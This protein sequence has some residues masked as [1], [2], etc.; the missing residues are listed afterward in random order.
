MTCD[1]RQ[2]ATQPCDCCEGVR[3][4][5]PASHQN[6][7]GLPALRYRVG[8]HGQ[9][10][11]SMQAR[12][13]S[14]QVSGVGSD[15]QTP[16]LFR[17]LQG[18]T[19]RDPGD[20]SIALLD[21]WATV[22]DVLGFYQE[23]IA[24]E[25]YL[26][27]ATERRS[28]LELARLVGYA[29]RPG[30][31]ASVHLAYTLDARQ[32]VPA[33]LPVGTAAQSTPDPGETPQ[34]FETAEPLLA[35]ADW[36]NLQVRLTQPPDIRLGNALQVPRLYLAGV[37]TQL[38]P[39]DKLLLMFGDDGRSTVVRTVDAVD[40][41]LTDQRTAVV[42]R[43]TPA[44]L[45]ACVALLDAA[46]ARLALLIG[47]TDA[48]KRLAVAGQEILQDIRLDAPAAA[49]PARWTLV[50]LQAD[51]SLPDD[52]RAVLTQ[53]DLDIAKALGQ[54]PD[55]AT[56]TNPNQFV[57]PLLLP[58]VVQARNTLALARD[59]R[60][61]FS[62][63]GLERLPDTG[64]GK[65][66]QA[67]P[68][69]LAARS[70]AYADAGTQL[71][72]S[73][74]PQLAESYYAA[75]AGANVNPA[76]APLKSVLVLRARSSLFGAVS[77][78]QFATNADGT[79][80]AQKDWA[81]WPYESDESDS[82]AFL[83]QANESVATGGFVLT[84][85]DGQRQVLRVARA[86][87]TP[88]TAYGISGQATQVEFDLPAGVGWRST[89]GGALIDKLRRTK[90]YMQSEPLTLA[91]VPL[92]E[93]VGPPVPDVTGATPP[94]QIPLAGLYK[95]LVSGRWVI[96]SG[97]RAD[98][99]GVS[100]VKAAEL[101]M[102]SGLSHGFDPALPGDKAHTTLVLA[103]DLAYQYKRA[104]LRIY[105]N[106]VR[107]TQ[108]ATR[109][110]TL[111]SGD[112][113][114]ALQSFTL[115]QGPL[116][117]VSAPNAAGVDSTLQAFV[118]DVEWH[119]SASLAFLGPRSRGFATLTDDDGNTTLTF[120][121]GEHGARLP[122]GAQNVRAVYR[123]GIGGGGNVKAG[124]ITVLQSRPPGVTEVVNP[125][126]ASGGAD[127]ESRDL[128]RENAPLAV[129]A[130]DRLVSVQDYQDF[131]RTFA[132][133]AKA[134]ARRTSDGRREVVYLT[135]A[136][137]ADAPIDP[138]SDLYLDLLQALRTSGDDALPLR[139]DARERK[140]LVLS[141]RIRLLPDFV[142]DPVVTAV[143]AALLDAFGFDRRAL[144]QWALLS[145]VIAAIQGVRGVA[146]VD[147]DAFGGVA[148]RSVQTVVAQNG[149]VQR[150]RELLTQDDVL[151]A[152]AEIVATPARLTPAQRDRMPPSVSAWPGGLDE[153][154][155]L[156]PA[157]L[158][159][160]TPSVPD[161]LILNQVP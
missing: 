7:P 45:L 121:N 15:G 161:T 63:T 138:S 127:R 59:L 158:V 43:P 144:G 114:Q 139:V 38:K 129:T 19:T 46:L 44:P 8:T 119:E 146:W 26:R 39:G 74:A 56:T 2:C 25:A 143:R 5:T 54:A 70:R 125:L 40:T 86:T 148:E 84:E 13:S 98:I 11:Q 32:V 103:T 67:A 126:R 160:F 65:D 51:D 133:I 105:G 154:G 68:R 34:T 22:G 3:L 20:A 77:A 88:R 50:L 136:G 62:P 113:A 49:P 58:P 96:V 17:P 112:G 99:D 117:W 71:L 57:R 155:T 93:T 106:V 156:R 78:R 23:R 33:T 83:D 76:S 91:E 153:D 107:A 102:I 10:L 75:W 60:S 80:K 151:A 111:G 41:Q 89:G 9:F 36:N 73:F 132:G 48:G 149:D 108:G 130:L 82:N 24:N 6:R 95:Q 122:T 16:T 118:D 47:G 79:L 152:V 135:I 120:G 104:T 4:L 72:V 42:L 137:V 97:E 147:V 18:L 14:L 1:C 53:L 52:A 85:I 28:V 141:A 157:E 27:T 116:T 92:P 35:S 100:G 145:E 55:Q 29:P 69:S 124:Q 21:A 134:L 101:Q 31:A 109:R 128:A 110:E 64:E 115:K 87:T 37:A 66:G 61:T 30:V 142:W 150:T 12:L 159:A 94:Q 131:A 81:E 90:L 123:S 140:A